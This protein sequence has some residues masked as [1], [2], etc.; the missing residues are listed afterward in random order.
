LFRRVR[1]A[2]RSSKYFTLLYQDKPEFLQAILEKK[3]LNKK[4]LWQVVIDARRPEG[5]IVDRFD[6]A[7]SQSD[8]WSRR[9]EYNLSLI[10]NK[11][12]EIE[13]EREELGK[14]VATTE[15]R[16]DLLDIALA[17]LQGLQNSD[18]LECGWDI[19]WLWDDGEI[20]QGF[21]DGSIRDGSP[22]DS[23]NGRGANRVSELVPSTTYSWWCT[24]GRDCPRHQGW[25]KALQEDL[26]LERSDQVIS[27]LQLVSI[28]LFIQCFNI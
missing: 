11:L 12:G 23:F 20:Q 10:Q 19:R 14:L 18:G 28:M 21:E 26:E 2:C 16:Q 7:I 1:S 15:A 27:F 13:R 9:R 8:L 24:E 6:K 3:K 5:I 25:V 22:V 17:R 4:V